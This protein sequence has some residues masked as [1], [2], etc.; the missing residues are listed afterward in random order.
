MCSRPLHF[1]GAPRPTYPSACLGAH[2]HATPPCVHCRPC[3][4]QG[5]AGARLCHSGGALREG[6]GCVCEPGAADAAGGR[7][8]CTGWNRL[9]GAHAADAAPTSLMLCPRPQGRAERGRYSLCSAAGRRAWRGGKPSGAWERGCAQALSLAASRFCM[10]PRAAVDAG[11]AAGGAHEQAAVRKRR[12]GRRRGARP[13]RRG[14]VLLPA[15]WRRAAAR[16]RLCAAALARALR[17]PCD[18]RAHPQ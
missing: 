7:E 6:S 8:V 13:H 12:E 2:A 4:G 14:D 15:R 5:A 18:R 1:S 3:A 17:L 9:R 16:V 11:S 10:P